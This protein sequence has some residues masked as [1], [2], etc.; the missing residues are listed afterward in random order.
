MATGGSLD[1]RRD[2]LPSAQRGIGMLEVLIALLIFATGMM[3]LITTQLAGKKA[4][5]EALQRSIATALARD[6]I[7]RMRANPEHIA[8]YLVH[9]AGDTEKPLSTPTVNCERADCN[10]AQLAAFDIWQWEVQ[11]L[12]VSEQYANGN[13]GGLVAPRACISRAGGAVS[14]AISWLGMTSARESATSVCGRDVAGLYDAP[15]GGAGNNQRRRQMVISTYV[16]GA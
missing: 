9:N 1:R 15:G 11:L 13:V 14:V 12:G 4:G 7:E 10:P 3:G 16:G 2:R 6:V 5:Y 8:A